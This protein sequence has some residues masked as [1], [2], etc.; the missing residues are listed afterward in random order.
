MSA[1]PSISDKRP[2][3]L[4][5]VHGSAVD[6]VGR[7]RFEAFARVYHEAARHDLGDGDAWSAD[8]L[9]EMDSDSTRL[10]TRF[11]ALADE[12]VCGA[13]EVVVPVKDNLRLA[14][15]E[16]AVVPER[17]RSGIGTMLLEAVESTAR[18]HG[19][20]TLVTE[21]SWRGEDPA[22]GDPGGRFARRFGYTPA[23]TMLRSDY[24]VPEDD[25]G[26]P[27]V[28]EGYAVEARAGT[29]PPADRADRA[30]L[31]R[32]MS[33][34]APLGELDLEEEEW[35]EERVA[36]LDA[37]LEAMGRGRAGAFARHLESGHLVG[38]TEIQV[39][40]ESPTLAYQQDTLVLREHRGHGL[41]LA[42]K[43]ANI[44]LLRT[45]YPAVRTVRTWNA[46]ENAHM[47]A[48][49]EAMGFRASGFVREW[50]KRL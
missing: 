24:T 10:R 39:P 7:S 13:A 32:R 20:T 43:L 49:N 11:A 50:Q 33:V 5:R 28:A 25:P 12:R 8:E 6:P 14:Y 48:V 37:R 4:V 31:A 42:V 3:R 27:P 1:Q 47:L 15:F 23:Q 22:A 34:D 41:G 38:F 30:W 21:T 29:P 36:A 9:R 17:R 46:V 44:A 40:K 18:E 35:D 45:A 19:R 16:L 2:A 26:P